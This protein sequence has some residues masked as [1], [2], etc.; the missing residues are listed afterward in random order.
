MTIVHDKVI[1]ADDYSAAMK[2]SLLSQAQFEE[3]KVIR[4]GFK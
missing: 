1:A 3:S 2:T 4:D